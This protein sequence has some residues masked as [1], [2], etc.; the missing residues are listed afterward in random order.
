MI[1]R[2]EVFTAVKIQIVVFW[3]MTQ[4]S[5][6][7]GQCC[8]HLQGEMN[9]EA[10]MYFKTLVGYHTPASYHKAKERKMMTDDYVMFQDQGDCLYYPAYRFIYQHHVILGLLENRTNESRG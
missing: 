9:K 8:S 6:V 2:Y 7:T 1:A 4:C 10:A 5:D 3:V